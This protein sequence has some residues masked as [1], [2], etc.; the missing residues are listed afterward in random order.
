M[1]MVA[2]IIKVKEEQTSWRKK[3]LGLQNSFL[4]K[5]QSRVIFLLAPAADMLGTSPFPMGCMKW[6]H[7]VNL[8]SICETSSIIIFLPV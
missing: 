1:V 8:E 5:T 4:P 3:P 7:A 2:V 6:Q